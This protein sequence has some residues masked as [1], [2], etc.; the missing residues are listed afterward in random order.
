[1]WDTLYSYGDSVNDYFEINIFKLLIIH[2]VLH[3]VASPMP[4]TP[5][6]AT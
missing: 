5:S 6:S 1:M 3:S 4:Y 2:I